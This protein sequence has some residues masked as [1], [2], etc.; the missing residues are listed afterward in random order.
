MKTFQTFTLGNNSLPGSPKL[1]KFIRNMFST[2]IV[3]IV[4]ESWWKQTILPLKPKII[5]GCISPSTK[6]SE[7]ILRCA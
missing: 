6:Y 5:A 4:F 2:I 3:Q 7:H 1:R